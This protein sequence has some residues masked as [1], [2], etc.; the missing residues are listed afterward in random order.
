MSGKRRAFDQITREKVADV[1]D[2]ADDDV[3][4]EEPKKASA[5]VLAKRKILTPRGLKNN[6]PATSKNN[7]TPAFKFGFT[8]SIKNNSPVVTPENNETTSTTFNGFNTA[9]SSFSESNDKE[10]EVS[11]KPFSNN[12]SSNISWSSTKPQQ[13]S[14]SFTPKNQ[15]PLV[16]NS[17]ITNDNE[18]STGNESNG[19]DKGNKI[20]ALNLKFIQAIQNANNT[21][22]FR[23]ILQKYNEFF[24]KIEKDEI[25]LSPMKNKNFGIVENNINTNEKI[26]LQNNKSKKENDSMDIES[27]EKENSEENEPESTGP[28][29]MFGKLTTNE[30]SVFKF[31]KAKPNDEIESSDLKNNEKIQGPTFKTNVGDNKNFFGKFKL[32]KTET[33]AET[34]TGSKIQEQKSAPSFNFSQG[35][36]KM[37]EK[38]EKSAQKESPKFTFPSNSGFNFGKKQDSVPSY[39]IDNKND[40]QDAEA[41][42]GKEEK[43]DV[44]KSLFGATGSAF[45]F[46][47]TTFKPKEIETTGT[48]P[49]STFNF[50]SSQNISTAPTIPS[51][52]STK[53]V[54]N[55][56]KPANHDVNSSVDDAKKNDVSINEKPNSGF[57]SSFNFGKPSATNQES[58]DSTSTGTFG[59]NSFS[60]PAIDDKQNFNFSSNNQFSAKSSN[61]FSFGSNTTE[62]STG[63]FNFTFTPSTSTNS[64][65]ADSGKIEDNDAGNNKVEEHE[66]K[67]DFKPVIELTKEITDKTTGEENEVPLY[68]K[69]SKLLLFQ[70]QDTTNPYQAKGLGELKL[71][72]DKV[73]KKSRFL[74]R[75]DGSFRILL[76]TSVLKNFKYEKLGKGN[77]IKVPVINEDKSL[78]TYVVQV[79]TPS[80]GDEFLAAIEK[81]KEEDSSAEN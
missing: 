66:V 29:F 64:V 18:S 39:S 20:K 26:N 35:Q 17:P 23:P 38:S 1:E 79:K 68:T 13:N 5:E 73:T 28:K 47:S 71:L 44:T 53:S 49:R 60:K 69:R 33:E 80:D 6:V 36:E 46:G 78:E 52:P 19:H 8:E 27:E 54:F 63:K 75:S 11:K 25:K 12:V 70:P 59:F 50:G 21:S 32:D 15:S 22:D 57:G 65:P 30:N 62:S 55:S 81:A 45:S 7:S 77:M 9:T 4:P 37:L 58:T 56:E 42:T 72:Q 76:N 10:P 41:A 74:I 14:F 3:L 16:L 61:P 48:E 34:E 2:D 43:K 24:E 31:D 51:Q 67:G 40:K